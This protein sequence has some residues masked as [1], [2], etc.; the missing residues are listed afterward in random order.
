VPA[1]GVSADSFGPDT[2][3]AKVI[4]GDM[5]KIREIFIFVCFALGVVSLLLCV[6][7]G[8]NGKF[9][10]ASALLIT[11][12]VCGVFVFLSQVKTF[13]VW[14]VQVELKEQLDQAQMSIAQLRRISVNSAKSIYGQVAWG[15]RMA[16]PTAKEKKAQLDEIEN[17]FSI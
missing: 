8:W 1:D 6:F 9:G 4:S 16:S 14:E 7:Q 15:N 17:N 10:S 11:A 3:E 13:K 12:I 2:C 5:E